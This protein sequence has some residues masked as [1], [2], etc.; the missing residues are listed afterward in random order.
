MTK[1]TWCHQPIK[2]EPYTEF[3]EECKISINEFRRWIQFGY[4]SDYDG[5]GFYGSENE[6]SNIYADFDDI[7]DN[8][9]EE[10]VTCVCWYNK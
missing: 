6:L 10:W 2:F 8:N 4:V 9:I 5:Y 1:Q 3:D 7:V